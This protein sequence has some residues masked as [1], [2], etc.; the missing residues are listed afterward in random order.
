MFLR[1]FPAIMDNHLTVD[2]NTIPGIYER[3]PMF[4]ITLI[5]TQILD[6]WVLHPT[7]WDVPP[8]QRHQWWVLAMVHYTLPYSQAS[9][10]KGS[11]PVVFGASFVIIPSHQARTSMSD[12]LQ[13]LKRITEDSVVLVSMPLNPAFCPQ[14]RRSKYLT[15]LPI[16][17]SPNVD[18][19]P[20]HS[21]ATA[22][23]PTVSTQGVDAGTAT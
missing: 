9:S 13:Y 21:F 2:W 5:D 3:M 10:L 19:G 18:R 23:L 7:L 16:N 11:S 6:D 12:T 22:F 4:P 8:K 15:L 1:R 14:P 20:L 17:G